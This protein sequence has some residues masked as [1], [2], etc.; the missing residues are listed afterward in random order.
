MK[1]LTVIL[2]IMLL[3]SFNA[4]ASDKLI[5]DVN[6]SMKTIYETISD[7]GMIASPLA[8][9]F[10]VIEPFGAP[11]LTIDA[12]TKME[13][14]AE[15]IE[16]IV[17]TYSWQD[18]ELGKHTFT[19]KYSGKGMVH[20]EYWLEFESEKSEPDINRAFAMRYSQYYISTLDNLPE[21]F[22]ALEVGVQIDKETVLYPYI[23]DY[24]RTMMQYYIKD[25]QA[26]ST[27]IHKIRVFNE[28]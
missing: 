19:V 9:Y 3:V 27:F 1:K 6:K 8:R 16:G 28:F 17:T 7:M 23:N 13:D 10:L 14:S 12:S 21:F 25:P 4:V 15:A 20:Q 11:E 2:A 26:G 24:D 5:I 22:K 18:S